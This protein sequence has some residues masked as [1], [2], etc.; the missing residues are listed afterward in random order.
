MARFFGG[1]ELWRPDRSTEDRPQQGRVVTLVNRKSD[2]RHAG[3]VEGIGEVGVAGLLLGFEVRLIVEFNDGCDPQAALGDQ[4]EVGV[5]LADFAAGC[6]VKPLFRFDQVRE[7]DL[8]H[9][10]VTVFGRFTERAVE[11]QLAR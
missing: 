9:H 5:A 2:E 7:A 8:A 1:S 6:G 10:E 3:G 11:A 4:H